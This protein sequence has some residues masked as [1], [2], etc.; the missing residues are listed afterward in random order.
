MKYGSSSNI[1]PYTRKK[2][3][4]YYRRKRDKILTFK[5]KLD[6]TKWEGDWLLLGKISNF[7]KKK[8]VQSL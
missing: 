2:V 7:T 3:G 8:V 5:A 1:M 4:L 6:H